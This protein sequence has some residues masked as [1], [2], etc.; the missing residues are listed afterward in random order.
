VTISKV[1]PRRSARESVLKA[2]Y[3]HN[4]LEE[5]SKEV[6]SKVLNILKD[7]EKN[8]D[9]SYVELLYES[10]LKHTEKVDSLIKKNLQNWDF[11][12]IAELDK[13][14]LRMG[15]CEMLFI[16]DVPPKASITEMVEISKVYSTDESPTFI[17]GILDAVYNNYINQ[18]KS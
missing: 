1:H 13:I 7:N 2:L 6:L 3:A 11:K 12:R 16:D 14:L 4:Y 18:K 9:T 5:N 8:Y 15:V 10:V 17:N